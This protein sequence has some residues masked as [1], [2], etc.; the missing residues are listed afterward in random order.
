MARNYGELPAELEARPDHPALAAV[1][2]A[3]LEAQDAAYLR[4]LAEVRRAREMPQVALAEKLRMA[5]PSVSR[6]ERQADEPNE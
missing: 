5:Q 6:L 4:R 1:A 2:R 3:Q